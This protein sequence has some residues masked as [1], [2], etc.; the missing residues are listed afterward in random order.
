[1][2][3]PKE[4]ARPPLSILS[5]ATVCTLRAQFKT[6]LHH[7]GPQ[8]MYLRLQITNTPSTTPSHLRIAQHC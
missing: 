8:S 3:V 5:G 1:M 6:P 2:P 7:N 4:F